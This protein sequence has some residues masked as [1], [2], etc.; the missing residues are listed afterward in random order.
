MKKLVPIYPWPVHSA[1]QDVLDGIPDINVV[2]ALPGGPGPILAIAKVPPFA[3][4]AIVVKAP[5]HIAAAIKI[6]TSEGIELHTV[7]DMVS[8]WMGSKEP[9]PEKWERAKKGPV[10]G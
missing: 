6:V 7:R 3:C 8:E 5:E 1:V 10:F 2:E 4:D 9:F